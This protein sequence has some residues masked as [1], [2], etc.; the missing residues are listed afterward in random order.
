MYLDPNACNYLSH[1]QV[2]YWEQAVNQLAPGSY[3]SLQYVYR[4]L[5]EFRSKY[6]A[7][8]PSWFRK[9]AKILSE[10]QVVGTYEK[11]GIMFNVTMIK[12]AR[13]RFQAEVRALRLYSL[14]PMPGFERMC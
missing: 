12:E 8:K 14:P 9:N 11:P 4:I 3:T 2:H 6:L 13:A 5:A 1:G 10:E 7:S